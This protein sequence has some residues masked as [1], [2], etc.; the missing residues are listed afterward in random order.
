MF[1]GEQMNWFHQSSAVQL[2]AAGSFLVVVALA[3]IAIYCVRRH[4][5]RVYEEEVLE[6]VLQQR[7]RE[8]LAQ[9][10]A[11]APAPPVVVEEQKTA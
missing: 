2:W 3:A 11:K 5:R 10:A 1:Q 9:I 4:R 7:I 6:P 8:R